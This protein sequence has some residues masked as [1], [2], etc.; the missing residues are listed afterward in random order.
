VTADPSFIPAHV[1]YP[2]VAAL[3]R[4]N[5]DDLRAGLVVEPTASGVCGG[6]SGDCAGF[7]TA[8]EVPVPPGAHRLVV[9]HRTPRL[10]RDDDWKWILDERC[11]VEIV[12]DGVAVPTIEP[13]ITTGGVTATQ[14]RMERLVVAEVTAPA[15]RAR[16][17]TWKVRFDGPEGRVATATGAYAVPAASGA[18]PGDAPAA[19]VA[20]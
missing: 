12:T 18:T 1:L 20:P 14:G 19:P 4:P 10:A 8:A 3:L 6:T 15:E 2:E 13:R 11:A 7:F 16:T 5:L 17:C 9:T